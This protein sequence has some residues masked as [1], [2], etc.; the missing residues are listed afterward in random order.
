IWTACLAPLMVTLLNNKVLGLHCRL[1]PITA[2]SAVNPSLLFV[3]AW[4]NADSA[5][6][7]RGPMMRSIWATS[8]PSPTNASPTKTLLIFAMEEILPDRR[9][10][11]LLSDRGRQPIL[12]VSVRQ[13]PEPVGQIAARA[14][15]RPSLP[16][17][18]PFMILGP[19]RREYCRG[20]SSPP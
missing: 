14:Y 3:N 1:G 9:K 8:L 19:R 11:A 4:Q 15:A 2:R 5:A 18:R 12:V 6:L 13:R 20:T 10:A 17:S 7:P 16:A